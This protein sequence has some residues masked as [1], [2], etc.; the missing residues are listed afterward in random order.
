LSFILDLEPIRPGE[1]EAAAALRLLG[2]LRR[3]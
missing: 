3:R 1:D 2:R